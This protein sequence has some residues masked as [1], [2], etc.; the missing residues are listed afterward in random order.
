MKT[1]RIIG[2]AVIAV[3]MSVNFA[4]CGDDD[5]DF[6]TADLI[7]L[8]EGVSSDSVEKENGQIV[9]TDTED[10]SDVRMRFN[11]DG[12]LVGYEKVNGVWVEEDY[13]AT[14]TYKDG[15]LYATSEDAENVI[16]N[17]IEVNSERLVIGISETATEDGIKYEYQETST[18]KK[19]TE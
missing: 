12:T 6:D 13:V 17:V 19:V 14:W 8:W 2:M 1:L 9:D 11:S 3:I 15:K 10:L 7:G 5:D 16:G 4:A 18:Y